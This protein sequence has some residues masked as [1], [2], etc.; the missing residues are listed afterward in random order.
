M[1]EQP[2]DHTRSEWIGMEWWSGFLFGG[3]NGCG[4]KDCNLCQATTAMS[5][6]A[7]KTRSSMLHNNAGQ[8]WVQLFPFL[9]WLLIVWW[10]KVNCLCKYY[11]VTMH[12][13]PLKLLF[14]TSFLNQNNFFYF[15]F[16]V[17]YY[18]AFHT[19]IAP[20][21]L[22]NFHWCCMLKSFLCV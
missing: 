4:Q 16:D 20:N 1:L 22:F 18:I 13:S 7:S 3:R 19:L 10:W 6:V 15:L 9:F 5:M 17:T 2:G 11:N 8:N 12:M 21:I 14:F